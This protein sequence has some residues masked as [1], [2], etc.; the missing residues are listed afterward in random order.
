VSPTF[1]DRIQDRNG[2]TVFRHDS[3]P[4]EECVVSEWRGDPIPEIPDLRETV[5]SPASAYQIVSMLKGVV[6]RGTGRRIRA[7]GKPLAGKT[8]TTNREMDTWFIGFAPD[9]AV[10][11]FAGF[12]TPRPLG[13]RETG[14]SVAA[15]VFRDFMALALKDKPSIP[16]RIPPSVRLVRVEAATGRAARPG[17]KQVILEAYKTGAVDGETVLI[18]G[19]DEPGEGGLAGPRLNWE[20]NIDRCPAGFWLSARDF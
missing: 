11:V 9:L 15:P 14:S 10:G 13:R 4:C 12:D 8:G 16:F 20:G 5:T 3:R 7:V 17:D 18:D 2:K 1:I 6:Q 19:S